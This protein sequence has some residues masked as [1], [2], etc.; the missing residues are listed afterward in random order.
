MVEMEN[1]YIKYFRIADNQ[2][3]AN[4]KKR[5]QFLPTKLEKIKCVVIFKFNEDVRK[6]ILSCAYQSQ[7][8]LKYLDKYTEMKTQVIEDICARMVF[9]A[10]SVMPKTG[11]Y[12]QQ[13]ECQIYKQEHSEMAKR[14]P[15]HK[16]M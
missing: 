1:K 5:I 10:M 7:C 6:W 13:R 15:S 12:H 2:E 4:Y 9:T 16:H 14:Q 3:N 11:N 8:E